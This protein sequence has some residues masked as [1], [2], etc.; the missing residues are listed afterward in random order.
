[1]EE[2]KIE[3][4]ENCQRNCLHCSSDAKDLK[5]RYLDIEFIKKLLDE[6]KELGA[7]S[8]VFTGGEATLYPNIEKAIRYAK[9]NGYYVKMYTM[10]TP[11]DNSLNLLHLLSMIGLDEI[12]YSTAYAL[13]Q[14]G[15]VTFDKLKH[16]F[17]KVLEKTNIKLGVHHVITKLTLADLEKNLD[18]FLSLPKDKTKKFSILRYIPHGRGDESLLLNDE[19][20]SLFKQ[21]ITKLYNE[22]SDKIRLGSPWNIL[23]LSYTECNAA[24][25]NMII[26]FDGNVYP[27][28]AMKYFDYLGYGG[29]AHHI[30]LK[31]IYN[32]TYFE[33]I[34]ASKTEYGEDCQKC[35]KFTLCKG[36]CLGQKMV[37]MMH[38]GTTFADYQKHALRT[39]NDFK[40]LQETR[41][42][43]E[44]GI[45]GEVGELIDIFKKYMTH[46]LTD[47]KKK[48]M[49][50][51]ISYELG[52]IAWYLAASL[53]ESYQ[54]TFEEVG[55]YIANKKINCSFNEQLLKECAKEKDPLCKKQITH[56]PLKILDNKKDGYNIETDWKKLHFISNNILM[57]ETKEEVLEAVSLL[58]IELAAISNYILEMSFED[59]INKNIEKLKRRYAKGFSAQVANAR[60]EQYDQYKKDEPDTKK[61][62]YS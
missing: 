62:V 40:N 20:F 60:I 27:C 8:V 61:L 3:V 10:C 30:S 35:P 42:N 44:M 26:G 39:M 7:S 15:V 32:S 14:D 57:A 19:E 53:S 5:Y 17:P 37:Q 23:G 58:L 22:H 45:A 12:I 46:S 56:I 38:K 24:Y 21:I 49:L 28:D 4:T 47:E 33:N 9:K 25:E 36:G 6:G 54:Y 50:D 13:T 59:I 43:G 16:F 41:M 2:I 48:Q 11:D 18:L 51:N 55:A 1:M 29:N 52:D 31:E 34:R